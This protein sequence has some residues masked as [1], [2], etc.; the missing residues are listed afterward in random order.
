MTDDARPG[1]DTPLDLVVIG[2]SLAGLSL[3]IEAQEAGLSRVVVC[4]RGETVALPEVIGHHGLDVRFRTGMVSLAP[5]DDAVEV[6]A[7]GGRLMATAVVLA[8]HPPG[9]GQGPDYPLPASL[10]DRIHLG[11]IPATARGLDVL[12][13]GGETAVEWSLH[14]AE[15][16]AGLVV[17][18]G[19]TAAADL[20]RLARRVLLRLEAERMATVLWHSRPDEVEDLDGYPMAYFDDRRTPDLQFDHLVYA[21]GPEGPTDLLAAVEIG[22]SLPTGAVW[23]VTGP[24]HPDVLPPGV[25]A[26]PAGRAWERLRAARFPH[27]PPR[28]EV[29]QV[30]RPGDRAQ[31]EELRARHYNAEVT[32]FE[33]AHSDLWVIRVR[34]DHGDTS[35]LAGQYASLG[36]G[37]WEPRGDGALDPGIDRTWD[38]LIRR[39]Y[40][41]SNPIFDRYGYLHDAARS[42]ELEFYVVLVPPSTGRVPALTPRLALKRPGDRIYLGPKVAGRYTL[43]PVTDPD[44][45]VLFLATGTGEAP[46]NAMVVELLRKGHRG[47]IASVVSVRKTADLGYL[48]RHRRLV[49]RF[50][51]FAYLPLPTREPGVERAYVQDVL[52]SDLLAERFGF[53]LDP[54]RTHVYLCGN[55]AMIG[56][57]EWT[58]DGPRFPQPEGVC[59]LLVARGFT[60]DRRDH[61]GTIH[62]EEY[63]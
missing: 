6:H 25:A 3:A 48:E 23:W 8:E 58:E 15:G 60:L 17:A 35:H 40:S 1:S 5:R 28:V 29:P 11:T 10:R 13:V 34:P 37:Y 56:L 33:R 21:L 2:G 55:P 16:G 49:E 22:Q 45:Q 52:R 7:A 50:P 46:H 53:A 30:W 59:E 12:V 62:V 61:L 32:A 14:L 47:P 54:A 38:R 20:S 27:L 51:N 19:G 63:W 39:S 44:S 18:L 42:D 36:L 57:P 4:V 41:I 24:A 26:A 31:I 9:G 43:A